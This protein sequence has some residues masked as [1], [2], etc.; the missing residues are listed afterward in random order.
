MMLVPTYWCNYVQ[1]YIILS[2]CA[3]CYKKYGYCRAESNNENNISNLNNTNDGND[4]NDD[5]KD[6]T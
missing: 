4:E 5:E 6:L 2:E 3:R 1:R